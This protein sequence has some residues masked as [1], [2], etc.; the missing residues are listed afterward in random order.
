MLFIKELRLGCLFLIIFLD[1]KKKTKE[2]FKVIGRTIEVSDEGGFLAAKWRTYSAF[3]G[4]VNALQ[5]L[6]IQY[7][8]VRCEYVDLKNVPGEIFQ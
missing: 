4:A 2:L 8:T 6:L 5:Q 1:L 3:S 7:A